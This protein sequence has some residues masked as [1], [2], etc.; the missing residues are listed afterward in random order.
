MT[1]AEL[2]RQIAADVEQHPGSFGKDISDRLKVEKK[3]VNSILF[4][5]LR[6]QVNQSKTYRWYPKDNKAAQNQN[7]PQE[8][9]F[10]NTP[11]AKLCRYY[12]SCLGAD[13]SS[14]V[15][16]FAANQYGDLDYIELSALPS[17]GYSPFSEE[18]A[19]QLLGK[20]RKDRGRLTMYFGYPTSL[21][22]A[23]SKKPG[24][25]WGGYFVEPILLFPVE[26][27]SDNSNPQL[28]LD[29][30]IFSQSVLKRFTN[31]ER[32]AL[33]DE[34]V[35]LED[36]L[37][38]SSEE[39]SLPPLDEVVQRLETIRPEWPWVESLNPDELNAETPLSELKEEGIYNRAVL[40]VGERSPFTQGLETE[41]SQLARL[42]EEK[43]Q[44]SALGDWLNGSAGEALE[45]GESNNSLIEVLPLN[46]EQRQSIEG[47]LTRK[48]TIITGPPGT[49]K[50]QVVTN[51]LINA[52]WQG[53][54]ILFASKNNKAV[55]VV[56]TRV[57]NLGPRPILLR[58]GSNQYQTRLAEYLISLLSS[59]S[60]SDD[61]ALF[62][63]AIELHNRFAQLMEDLE[64]E[65]NVLIVARN[66]V[67]SLEQ[68][69]ESARQ[70]HARRLDKLLHLNI[71]E[72][73]QDIEKLKKVVYAALKEEQP[74]LKRLFWRYMRQERL[75]VLQQCVGRMVGF[76][77]VFDVSV[78]QF[79]PDSDI[80]RVPWE[81]TLKQ[82]DE[83]LSQ[84]ETFQKY[85]SSMKSLQGMRSLPQIAK[86]RSTVSV[87]MAKNSDRLWKSWLRIRPAQ[88]SQTD[89]QKLTQ[90]NSVLKMVIDTG[91]DGRLGKEIY[92]KY[93]RLLS[94]AAHLLPCW[95]VTSLSAK[96]KVPFTPGVFD[97]VVFDEASQ[98]DIA[99]ALP[100]LYR[101]KCAVVIGDPKQL[102]H[103]S[104]L[105]K[106]QDQ[107][108][109]EKYGL[110]DDYANWAYSYNSLFDLAAGMSAPSD[111]VNLRDHHRSHADII[112]FSNRFFYE[113]RLRIA[114]NYDRLNR[115]SATEPGVRWINVVG[116]VMRPGSGGAVNPDE[117][118]AVIV[119]IKRLIVDQSYYGSIGV[120]SPFRAQANLIRETAFRDSAL[121]S[122]L[123]SR[124][125]LA[126]T[127][128][129]FQG[130]ERDLMI[131]SPVV[132]NGMTQGGLSFLRNNGNLF[133][134]AITRARAQL[135]VVGD[136]TAS[137][138]SGIDYLAGFVRYIDEMATTQAQPGK[139]QIGKDLGSEYPEPQN[140]EMVSD[141]ERDFY[142]ALHQAGINTVP[143]FRVEKYSLD[144]ALFD[145]DRM[146]DIEVDGERYHRN[147]DGE[148]CRRDQMR[149]Q[150]LIE[151][152]WDVQRFWVY[153]IR[154]DL[155]GCVNK[156][157]SWLNKVI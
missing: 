112:E 54:R 17:D 29:F 127:V 122:I 116:K 96:G 90:Y 89:R 97:I 71:D 16:V 39:G 99:S 87:Q 25:N 138:A 143:Q 134:V 56:E 68:A 102:S 154:D 95:S 57:N 11:L 147:W 74:L 110:V 47:A 32:E 66:T 42:P 49:G 65:E 125:F 22:Y 78:P 121:S 41:L 20:L 12:L 58:V 92:A 36:E 107:Q 157:K 155:D 111:I 152:G 150:R 75:D 23:R 126:D 84:A 146:L 76:M 26:F 61:R 34:L 123:P 45:L 139:E 7:E 94:E 19:S 81:N 10:A 98:C 48:L 51:L 50:S 104:G 28:K 35:Q 93:Y 153:E 27:E 105:Q 62:D 136:K 114:T 15:S 91:P 6:S 132:S 72:T 145:G 46:S 118:R 144:L 82:L 3:L 80:D 115:P 52:A 18:S 24:S 77:G 83:L 2:A 142:K 70:L 63:E 67:D 33:M 130:D 30:P 106:G 13:E 9:I 1:R 140:P 79:I 59:T 4:S 151:L 100:L 5:D 64:K 37:G 21:R 8:P 53:K 73:N 149:N 44:N 119:E 101:A 88:L 148:L 131:F 137:A 60:T 133:N 14:S 38:L 40:I 109:I 129:R 31:A 156:I 43:Y 141:W 128:H 108:L 86:E 55:D 85:Y 124:D 113:G 117:A 69:A 120:V 103:I 135:L